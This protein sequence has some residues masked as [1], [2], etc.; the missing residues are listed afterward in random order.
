MATGLFPRLS[1]L[2]M[3]PCQQHLV[4]EPLVHE[5]VEDVHVRAVLDVESVQRDHALQPQVLTLRKK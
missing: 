2:D 1:T 3:Y 4:V 5:V